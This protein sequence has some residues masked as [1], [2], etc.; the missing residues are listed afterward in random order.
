[1]QRRK[2]HQQATKATG[3]PQAPTFLSL[4]QCII[5]MDHRGIVTEFNDAAEQLLGHRREEL[6][7]RELAE[8]IV[9]VHLRDLHR[10]GLLH[11][12]RTGKGPLIGRRIEL[13]ALHSDGSLLPVEMVLTRQHGSEPPIFTALLRDLSEPDAAERAREHLAAVV[14]GTHD[15]VLSKNLNGIL[16]SWNPA[17]EQ[18]YG[19]TEEEAVGRHVSILIPADHQN[20]EEEILARIRQGERMDT[21][22]TERIRKDGARIDVSLTVSPIQSQALGII[23]ASVVA[24]DITIENRRRGAKDL[25][26]AAT[27]AFDASLDL[28]ETARTIVDSAVPELAEFCVIDFVR[29]DGWLGDSVVAGADFD[30]AARLEEIRQSVPLDPDGDHPVA[31]VLRAGRPMVWRDLT[32]AEMVRKVSQSDQHRRL[33]ESAGYRSAAVA[34]LIA[35]GRTLGTLSLLHAQTDMRYDEDDLELLTDMADRA[36]MALDNAR[37]YNERE[38]IAKNLQRGLRP[39]EPPPIPGLEFSVIFEAAGEGIEI[40]GDFY[41]I[42]PARDGCWILVGDVA[43]KGSEAAAVSVALRHSVRALAHE[44]DQPDA[45]LRRANDLLLEGR[46]LNDFA[47]A[48]LMRIKNE[49]GVKSLSLAAARHP[50]VIHL[51]PNG[52]QLLGGGAVMGAFPDPSVKSHRVVLGNNDTLV[53]CTDGWLEAGPPTAH[54]DPLI[55]AS[56]ANSLAHL[57]LGEMTRHLLL[58]AIKRGGGWLEDDMILLAVRPQTITDS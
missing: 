15:A 23:G 43:G 51:T 3:K 35:R 31:Q 55:L 37:L 6:L 53:L 36:A 22:E 12:L 54:R 18:L 11:Y 49:N 26:I 56:M 45:V 42:L 14:R 39:P 44:I 46:T 28:A 47:T 13:S 24:R 5:A 16:T 7:G 41:D 57:E 40:G 58:D 52:P 48:V 29:A 20:E 17:A 19:Y 34:G 30:A 10:G 1:M 2:V 21:Y 32:S 33:M 4:P 38:R 50:A 27:R 25:L 9:P 8:S